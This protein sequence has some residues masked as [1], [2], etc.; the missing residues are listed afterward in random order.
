ML[1]QFK[2]MIVSLF[3][4]VN[5]GGSAAPAINMDNVDNLR[6]MACLSQAVHG[7]AGNQS[8][9]G[10]VAVAFV[11]LNRTKDEKFPS[12]I[13]AVIKQKGQFGFLK[14]VRPLNE[15]NPALRAQMEECIRATSI[16][17]NGEMADPTK[18]ALYFINPKLATDR[19]WLHKFKKLAQIEDH[20]FYSRKN[21]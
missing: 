20:I 12:D 21:V 16:A 6:E 18:G 1:I 10:K 19:A 2:M 14:R 3:M 17:M 7:E 13:C 9:K 4:A 5:T 15:N 11:I 8:L